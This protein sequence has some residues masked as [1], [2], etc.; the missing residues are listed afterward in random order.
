MNELRAI[1]LSTRRRWWRLAV[2]R[3][4]FAAAAVSLIIATATGLAYVTGLS[5]VSPLSR[6]VLTAISAAALIIICVGFIVT[7]RS[8]PSLVQAARWLDRD[9]ELDE[10]LSTALEIDPARASA[11]LVARAAIEDARAHVAR[12]RVTSAVPW[13]WPRSSR[14]LAIGL[15]GSLAVM[16]LTPTPALHA[17]TAS[18]TNADD[19]SERAILERTGAT[20]DRITRVLADDG[21][22]GDDAY[23]RAVAEA[24]DD[25]AERIRGGDL[26][27]M[28]AQRELD[29]L[30]SHLL[31][32]VQGRDEDAIST[33]V[34]NFF[35]SGRPQND[36]TRPAEATN[37]GAVDDEGDFPTAQ[38]HHE[39]GTASPSLEQLLSDLER[40]LA[41]AEQVAMDR[42]PP[43]VASD[44]AAGES[45]YGVDLGQL[46]ERRGGGLVQEGEGAGTPV[47]AAELS[48]DRP[49]DAAGEGLQGEWQDVTDVVLG[50]VDAR[51]EV[52]V[53]TDEIEGGRRITVEADPV[54][55]GAPRS[56]GAT[57]DA[58]LPAHRVD[59][60][61]VAREGFSTAYAAVVSTY[62]TPDQREQRTEHE[63]P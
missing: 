40:A 46:D 21:A 36:G 9:A 7:W 26:D 43:A 19:E 47:G 16:I 42:P 58:P 17:P 57:L 11:S 20:L 60:A 23:V 22:R 24:F 4:V 25:L 27:E 62:F 41:E 34:T 29:Q 45:L 61:A 49:G 13:R 31:R 10:R 59:E 48:D 44:D 3:S 1:A 52:T 37:E 28:Q 12:A 32:A 55:H 14:L 8:V 38:R 18:G 30:L 33:L 5:Q 53:A 6:E 15:T 51:D 56:G 54:D 63:R 2:L 35:D 50:D 39:P